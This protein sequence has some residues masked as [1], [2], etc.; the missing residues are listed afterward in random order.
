MSWW[1]ARNDASSETGQSMS[2]SKN[3]KWGRDIWRRRLDHCTVLRVICVMH[4]WV[5]GEFCNRYSVKGMEA[6]LN[7]SN[8]VMSKVERLPDALKPIGALEVTHRISCWRGR[9]W[10]ASCWH[11]DATTLSN[12]NRRVGVT[13]AGPWMKQRLTWGITYNSIK[14]AKNWHMIWKDLSM[15][16][17]EPENQKNFEDM[18]EL[19]RLQSKRPLQLASLIFT[20]PSACDTSRPIRQ[21]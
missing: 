15:V 5:S 10:Q 21:K 14:E 18:N 3:T 19:R 7:I 16:E 6:G 20:H 1:H 17:C 11:P 9:P 4:K 13:F 12:S 8:N 2:S